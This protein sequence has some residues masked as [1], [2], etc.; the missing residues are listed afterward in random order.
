M[1][2]APLAAPPPDLP[3]PYRTEARVALQDGARRFAAEQVRP[4]ADEY[5]PHKREMPRS[6]IEAMGRE[7]YFGIMVDA[8][9]GGLG[10]GVFEY[11]MVAEELARAWMSVASI[12]ARAQGLGT[13]V[14][15]EDRARE[16]LARSARGEWI[17]AAGF[18]EPDAGSDL[19][20]VS[21]RAELDG[22]EYVITGEKRWIGNAEAA[23]FIQ[24]LC[25]TDDPRPGEK[26]AAGLATV[27]VEK[28]R[29]AFPPGLT[30][31]TIDKI[32]YHGFLTWNLVFDGVRVPAANRVG[33][34]GTAA[35]RDTQKWLNIARVHTAARAV[36]LARAAVEDSVLY[37]QEREQ[38]GHPIADFQALRF[39]LASMVARV[40]Q[41]RA[42]YRQVADQ[43]DRGEPCERESAMVKLVATEMAVDVTGDAMQ[44]HGGNGYTTERQVERYWRDARLTTIFE[45]TSQIQQKI[46]ADSLLPKSSLE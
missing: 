27:I 32:G 43:L 45:G 5:D 28:E 24:L 3:G 13:D 23:D 30:G 44:L 39:M 34:K 29:G 31:T 26:R 37:L 18:S 40:D 7:G 35:F 10:L 41:A 12:I 1:T 8:E 14:A 9:H 6:L 19:A 36:G 46:I 38:F 11:T 22:D 16:L 33:G 20:A 25:R 2:D 42:F 4:I 17:G 15:E 21:T